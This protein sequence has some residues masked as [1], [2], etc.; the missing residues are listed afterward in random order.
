MSGFF[1]LIVAIL[2][3][4]FLVFIHELGH[5]GVG[6]YLGFV[7]L[8]FSVGMG[9]VIFKKEKNGTVYSLRLLPVGGMCRFL[10]EDEEVK[11]DRS[12]SAFPA[13]K[14]LITVAAGPATNIFLG[15]ILS[16]IMIVAYGS[17]L[18]SI[19]AV[20]PESP[21]HYSG[22]QTG[23]I[24]TKINGSDVLFYNEA[25]DSI[26]NAGND[27]SII[28]LRED[29]SEQI[30]IKNA[31]DAELG[32]S[33]IGVTLEP[34]R[35]H[36][37]FI[38]S[39]K[40]GLKNVILIIRSTLEALKDVFK[41]ATDNITGPVGTVAVISKAV[42]YGVEV[43]LELAV[44]INLSVG[45]FN[46]LPLPALDGG[47]L[48]FLIVEIV[49]RKPVDAEKEG[50]IHIIGLFLLFGLMILLTFKDIFRLIG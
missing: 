33:R 10:G 12:F 23:D 9:P 29:K 15:C 37:P 47:R 45:V 22:L 48:I 34:V 32:H 13:W 28:V 5:F 27:F 1:S 11:N 26:K 49:R 16:V 41:G 7:I 46:I 14:R 31:F 30:R 39:V 25:V 42:R 4:S 2:L 3:L 19:V 24:I 43:I 50:W 17:F 8:E 44:L 18:P 20:S 6:K 38:K 40:C 21:A 36:F 35:M